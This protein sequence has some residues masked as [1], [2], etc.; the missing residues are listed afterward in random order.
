MKHTT[1]ALAA[2]MATL[3]AGQA[4]AQSG[5]KVELYGV[6]DAYVGGTSTYQ[7][8][9]YTGGANGNF[10][11]TKMT[12]A[13]VNSGGISQSRIGVRVNEDLG[14]G[15]SA[16]VNIEQALNLDTGASAGAAR[17]SVVGLQSNW[18]SV[19][20]GRQASPYHDVHNDFDVQNDDRFSAIAGLPLNATAMLQVEAFRLCQTQAACAGNATVLANTLNT[21]NGNGYAARTGAFVGYQKRF[22][23]S[24]RYDSPDFNGFAFA[25]AAGGDQ[26]KTATSKA[27]V[28]TAFSLTYKN[29]PLALG[30]A[31][32]QEQEQTPGAR[33]KLT[34]TLLAGSYDFGVLRLNAGYNQAKYNIAGVRNQKES[35]VGLT[36]PLGAFTLVGQYAHSSGSSLQKAT[37]LAAELQYSLS[38]RSTIYGVYN[39]TKVPQ[40][41]R[42]QAYGVGMRHAF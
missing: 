9:G 5:N 24:I 21:I 39:N 17:R 23:N 13:V 20:L 36:A 34:N 31:R 14:N 2:L 16:F 35:F 10:L 19:S 27:A 18:G 3:T 8:T 26:N 15:L 6:A 22:N 40:G 41:Y 38:K 11:A 4:M 1:L 30:L 42:N 33:V 37:S 29:G 28:N 32:Q 7:Y 25:I 12:Q